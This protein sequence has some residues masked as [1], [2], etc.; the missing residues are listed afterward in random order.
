AAFPQPVRH[1]FRCFLL[2]PARFRFKYAPDLHEFPGEF[3]QAVGVYRGGGFRG[4]F[5][6]A[7]GSGGVNRPSAAVQPPS[8]L[9]SVPVTKLLA[10][11]ARNTTAPTSSLGWDQRLNTLLSAYAWYQSGWSLICCVSGVS[12]TPGATA[13]TRTLSG[14]SSAASAFAISS[15]PAFV[16]AYTPCPGSTTS[17]RMEENRMMLPPLP[18]SAMRR[19]ASVIA[20]NEPFRFT[21]MTRWN[22]SRLVSSRRLR[23]LM[24]GVATS[25]SR[26]PTLSSSFETWSVSVKS[27]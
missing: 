17:L 14:P 5:V 12:T 4:Q 11:L 7:H 19:P 15:V 20:T 18:L 13:F 9:S 23:T 26:L 10:W 6:H 22:S 27:T 2:V 1:E 21:S 24:D 8:T 25:T 3:H 16:A